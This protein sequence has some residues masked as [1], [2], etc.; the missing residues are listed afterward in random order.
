MVNTTPNPTLKEQHRLLYWVTALDEV[1]PVYEGMQLA[2][3][4]LKRYDEHW[5]LVVKADYGGGAWVSFH[6]GH[7]PWAC[8]M[9]LA[10]AIKHGKCGWKKDKYR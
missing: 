3:I 2:G 4:T 9:G 5:I 6:Y 8:F 10:L 7:R 1:L